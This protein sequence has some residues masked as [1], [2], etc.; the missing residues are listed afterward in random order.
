MH[1]KNFSCFYTVFIAVLPTALRIQ[2]F[3]REFET[4]Q[5]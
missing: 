5:A 1:F 4:V 3:S 2:G